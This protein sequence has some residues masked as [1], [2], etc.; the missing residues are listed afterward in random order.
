MTVTVDAWPLDDLFGP[1]EGGK[2]TA[3][4]GGDVS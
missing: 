4:I 3:D 1:K 2:Y